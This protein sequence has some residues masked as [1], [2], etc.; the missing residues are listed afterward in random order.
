MLSLYKIAPSVWN[1]LA[2]GVAWTT[3]SAFVPSLSFT[4]S[5]VVM[6]CCSVI[7]EI[8]HGKWHYRDPRP[9]MP[10]MSEGLF[11]A[12]FEHLSESE[13]VKSL[14]KKSD[15]SGDLWHPLM[16]TSRIDK[17]LERS[18]IANLIIGT[19][20]TGYGENIEIWVIQAFR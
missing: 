16:T 8:Y 6:I 14:S 10:S 19:L 17:V 15:Y 11:D 12:W 7:A 13:L 4:A 1:P 2:I 3:V 5:G 18:I 9:S 20:I